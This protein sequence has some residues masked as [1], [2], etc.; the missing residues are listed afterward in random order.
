MTTLGYYPGCS[1]G[2]TASEYGLSVRAVASRM[3]VQLT[4][5]PDWLC[6]GASSA[7][8]IDRS[9]ALCFAADTLAKA[10]GAGM[11]QVLAPCAMCYQRLATASHEL[12]ADSAFAGRVAEALGT[13]DP[14]AFEQVKALSLLDWLAGVPEDLIKQRVTRP[15]AGMKV[16]CYYGCLLVRPAAITGAENV[17]APR[18]M[19]KIV[20]ALGGQ[21]VRWSMA[22]ECCGGSFALSRKQV[23]LRQGKRIVEAARK[24]GADLICMACPMCHANIDLRQPEFNEPGQS[25]LPVLYLTQLMGLA[26]GASADELGLKAHFVSAEGIVEKLS[27]AKAAPTAGCL[28][29]T[30]YS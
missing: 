21:G 8:A 23:V 7:H 30:A 22:M 9:A 24:A 2:G 10:H 3:D 1:L 6:C 12:G 16:A 27:A 18:S 20:A 28:L 26:M 25:A 11:N 15:L 13:T 17:E 19:E 14:K 29:P 5:V 4:E